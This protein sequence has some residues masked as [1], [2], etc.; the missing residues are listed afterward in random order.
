M[1]KGDV[2]CLHGTNTPMFLHVFCGVTS[3]G[4]SLT[5]ANSQLTPGELL[6]QI[7]ESNSRFIV[8]TPDCVLNAKTVVK[9]CHQ[10]KNVIV[11]G[12]VE[13]CV[14]FSTIINDSN[15][16]L[17]NVNI[18]P[19]N[20]VALLPYSSG[21]TGLPKGVMLTHHNLVA[22]LSQLR[23]HLYLP[24]TSGYDVSIA[25]LPM[26]HIAGLV[27][28]LLNPVA[29]GA[30]V[31]TLPRFEP[32]TYL[33]AI[34]D[35]KGTF[36]LVAPPVVNFFASHPSV[37]NYDLSSFHTPYS[38][39]A[40]LRYGMSETSPATHTSPLDGWKFGS[41]GKPLPNTESKVVDIGTG[42]SLGI[43][44]HGELWV[45]GPQVMKGYLNNHKAT[46]EAI[47]SDGWIKTGDIGYYDEDGHY[48][49]ID[50]L[51]EIVKYKGYQ[52]AP[53]YLESVLLAHP[54][55]ADSA[56]IGI[57][58]DVTGALPRAFIVRKRDISEDKILQYVKD[59]V[60]PYKQLRG[61]VEFVDEIPKLPS[62]KI[63]RRKLLEMY[64]SRNKA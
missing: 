11:L 43:N 58:D 8:T 36:S 57:P 4:A 17:P 2:V 30:T 13:G 20:D 55:V 7:Q 41:I 46:E 54:D 12:D 34:Q 38:G 32:E 23:H 14:P 44:E 45:R 31:V 21:T 25:P 35:Y 52:V 10:V 9:Q 61:G 5:I 16:S 39:A 6:H 24:F 27:I 18:K 63:L 42:K 3:N 59:R 28:G 29:Q 53:A 48:Y 50:R 51:K 60:A 49:I 1:R 19:T 22:Q 62:G 26:V 37:D 15:C 47:N 40:P 64:S 56:V 33:K